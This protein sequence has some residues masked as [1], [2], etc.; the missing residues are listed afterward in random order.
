MLHQDWTR[1][2]LRRD[3]VIFVRLPGGRT[4]LR[5]RG[6]GHRIELDRRETTV[7]RWLAFTGYDAVPMHQALAIA[8]DVPELAED[9][10]AIIAAIGRLR[11]KGFL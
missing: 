8:A 1:G 4:A 3:A 7:A 9:H 2:A 5:R 11:R 10:A 6:D